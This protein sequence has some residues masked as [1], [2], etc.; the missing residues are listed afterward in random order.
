MRA[1]DVLAR[2]AA[3]TRAAVV[4]PAHRGEGRV[5]ASR[6]GDA[7]VLA[8]DG[9]WTFAGRAVRWRSVS[10]W[11]RQGEALRVEW[12][13][14]DVPAA[15]LLDRQPDGTWTSQAPFVCLPD[16]Y[17]ASLRV[18]RDAIVVAWR[19]VGPHKDAL[20]ETRYG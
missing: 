16:R 4:T 14:Q 17:S 11:H 2:L 9:T 1:T 7:L 19:I 13:R 18:E 8:A 12:R 20:V 15:V 10:Q 6:E 5:Q 3:S